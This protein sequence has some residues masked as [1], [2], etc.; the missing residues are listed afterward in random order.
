MDFLFF[1]LLSCLILTLTFLRFLTRNPPSAKLP[2]GP[3][4]LPIIG[5]LHMLGDKPHQSLAQL[6]KIHGPLMSLQLGR[7][8]TI[9]AS[10]PDTAREILQKHDKV[11]SDR[12]VPAA[13]QVL[14]IHKFAIPAL[15]V[16]PRWRNLRKL[17]NSYIFTTQKLDMNQDHRRV[18]VV[19]LLEGIRRHAEE[20][21]GEALDVGKAAFKASL[22]ALSSTVLSMDLAD[23]EKS[24]GTAREFKDL[25]RELLGEIGKPNLG[26][27]FPVVARLDLQ[28]IQRRAE[29]HARKMLN[30]FE[31][32][33]DQRL[34]N[35][36]SESYVSTND[37]LDTLLAMG[38]ID[39]HDNKHEEDLFVAGTDSTTSTLEWAM[40]ELLRNSET[41]TKAKI[42]LDQI[43][44]KYNH[45]QE[46]D[47]HRLPYLQAIVKETFR[48]HPP[49]PLL[50]PHKATTDV[51]IHGFTVP[52]AAQILVNVWAI[53]RDST[54]W[55]DPNSFIPGRFLD[56]KVDGK[57]NSFELLP[58]G[59]GRRS[60]PGQ[61][62]A[63]RM[64]HMMLG[65]LV[66][67][68][69]WKLPDGLKPETLD[70]EEN[71]GLTLHKAKHLF[72]IP[73]LR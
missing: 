35:L 67:G 27:Y 22:N 51:E 38:D 60:C 41:L 44:G 66:H 61:P 42:E 50:L 40:T 47:I 34:R 12:H 23:E 39:D 45:L 18:K 25:V 28:G 55:V 72:A 65:S 48:L 62:L 2:P 20:R 49:T 26:D 5:N 73:T 58:F 9:V 71:F 53:G 19:D 31:W 7:V 43:I 59:S 64:L 69:D 13:A 1:L 16:G 4:R 68:F 14:D 3:S 36:K 54:T 32:V 24:S 57:D 21:P 30:W 17:C 63:L 15:P 33:I 10:S 52:K 56:S 6:A 29:G 11:L 37:M 46:S 70:M 8:T